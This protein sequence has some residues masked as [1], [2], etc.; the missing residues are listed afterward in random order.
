MIANAVDMA[1]ESYRYIH[2]KGKNSTKMNI[3]IMKAEVLRPSRA[4]RIEDIE[5]IIDEWKEKQRY[6]EDFGVPSM[7]FDQKKHC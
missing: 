3:V 7:D 1:F 4:T 5:E 6:L 2:C